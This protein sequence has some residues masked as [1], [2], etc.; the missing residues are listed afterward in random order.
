[1]KILAINCSHNGSITTLEDG[2]ITLSIE[3]DRLTRVKEDHNIDPLC[4]LVKDTF[5]E[6]VVY[7]SANIAKYQNKFFERY[8]KTYLKKY[9]IEYDELIEFN[10][11][12]LTH[13]FAAHYNS[14]H[15][16][17]ICLV[18]DNGGL[19]L[20]SLDGK[21]LGQEILTI[22]K[23]DTPHGPNGLA[24]SPQLAHDSAQEVFKICRNEEGKTVKVNDWLYSVD[25]F[26]MAGMFLFMAKLFKYK[27]AG[28]IMGLSCYGK[29]TPDIVQEQPFKLEEEYFTMNNFLIYNLLIHPEV[30]TQVD[31]CKNL[32][33][34]CENIVKNYLDNMKREFPDLPICLSGGFFQNC[35]ANYSLLKSGYDF[36]VD[37]V[38]HDGGT[39]IGLAQHIYFIQT[40]TRP[41]PYKNLYLGLKENLNLEEIK[42]KTKNNIMKLDFKDVLPEDIARLLA[43]G[44]AVAIFQGRSEVGPRA[45]G[46]RSILFDPRDPLAKEKVN[47]IKH[48][49]WFRP[50]AGTILFEHK[51]Q[52]LNLSGKGHT[53]YM[54]YALEVLENKRRII[55]GITHVD[56]TCRAQTLK[57]EE[58]PNFYEVIEHFYNMTGVPILLNT[59]LNG[60]GEPLCQKIEDVFNLMRNQ[61]CNYLYLPEEKTLIY[62]EGYA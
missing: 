16:K 7:T 4:A 19:H 48:R 46:N 33:V 14:G 56:N 29:G 2:V 41:Q 57:K 11:H 54:S 35:V 38:A 44:N 20:E 62:K 17:S 23:M 43:E 59:S 58:N 27:E 9:N 52:W 15:D 28:S 10:K 53:P 5:F 18:T 24:G 36:F 55:P 60:V 30:P 51:D 50:Y 47:L 32:Q 21:K 31:V 22:V 12:H 1:M 40:G 45:L 42:N 61:S 6:V 39:S 34:G 49:E 37:P 3:S 26:S 25:T 13:A 8:V